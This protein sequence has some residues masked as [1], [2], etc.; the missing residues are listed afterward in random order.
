[1]NLDRVGP[2]KHVPA[3]INASVAILAQGKPLRGQ[4][5]NNCVTMFAQNHMTTV[6]PIPQTTVA[7][8]S[9]LTEQRLR[10]RQAPKQHDFQCSG[11]V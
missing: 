1:M 2:G 7:I 9:T 5:G 10:D 6:Q 11:V 4:T 3:G 8:P